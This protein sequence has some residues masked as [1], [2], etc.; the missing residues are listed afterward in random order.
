MIGTSKTSIET[1]RAALRME[2]KGHLVGQKAGLCLGKQDR[3]VAA[4][5]EFADHIRARLGFPAIMT[6][7]GSREESCADFRSYGPRWRVFVSI[8]TGQGVRG[9]RH[10]TSNLHLQY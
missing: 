4:R 9:P 6:K 8:P 3:K 5:R 1:T 10:Q 2:P 7:S